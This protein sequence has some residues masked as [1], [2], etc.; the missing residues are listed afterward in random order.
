MIRK[1]GGYQTFEG[2]ILGDLYLTCQFAVAAVSA[3]FTPETVRNDSGRSIHGYFAT[4]VRING[5]GSRDVTDSIS[6]LM[7][8]RVLKLDT[9]FRRAETEVLLQKRI[10][11]DEHDFSSIRESGDSLAYLSYGAIALKLTGASRTNP[12][13]GRIQALLIKIRNPDGGYPEIPGGVS[14]ADMS[15]TVLIAKMAPKDGRTEGFLHTLAGP[16]GFA[17]N[18]TDKGKGESSVA[19][20]A[21][22]AIARP[23]AYNI[24]EYLANQWTTTGRLDIFPEGDARQL[25]NL[26]LAAQVLGNPTLLT[27]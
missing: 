17:F 6:R 7:T 4:D 9:D 10:T 14:V 2:D 26:F 15:A 5:L 18:L 21:L 25:Y 13:F 22:V 12:L 19:T 24:P 1:G 11:A 27:A 16:T 3:G 23:G 20:T 8:S